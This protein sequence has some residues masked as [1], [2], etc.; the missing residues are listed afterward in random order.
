MSRHGLYG[1]GACK[2][3]LGLEKIACFSNF[4]HLLRQCLRQLY[5]YL[6]AFERPSRQYQGAFGLYGCGACKRRLGLENCFVKPFSRQFLQ[7]VL[8]SFYDYLKA[9]SRP[10][11]GL[12]GNIREPLAY[13]DTALASSALAYVSFDLYGLL[14][15]LTGFIKAIKVYFQVYFQSYF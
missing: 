12:L 1:C 6:K 2:H 13:E 15:I 11:Q 4:K 9:F 10:S 14:F 5:D 3:R 7:H 8:R